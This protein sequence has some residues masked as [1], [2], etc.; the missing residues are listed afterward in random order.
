MFNIV[1]GIKLPIKIDPL[2]ISLYHG[3]YA[4]ILVETDMARPPSEI[5]LVKKI[6]H[7]NY[8]DFKF[9]MDLEYETLPK[10]CQNCG[11]IGHDL[12]N[13]RRSD[14]SDNASVL[15]PDLTEGLLLSKGLSNKRDIHT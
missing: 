8:N 11:I 13:C 2:T 12:K 3:M 9:F 7:K 5:I 14:G 1:S 15:R 6:N 4:R 10:F